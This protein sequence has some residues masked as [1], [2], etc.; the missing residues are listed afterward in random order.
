MNPCIRARLACFGT[1]SQ[2]RFV[3][4]TVL[5]VLSGMGLCL[6]ARAAGAVPLGRGASAPAELAVSFEQAAVLA[7]ELTAGGDA[8]FFSVAREPQGYFNRIVRRAGVEVVDALGDARF[9]LPEGAVPLKSVWVVADVETG[10]CTVAAPSGFPLRQVPFPGKAFEVGPPGLVNRLRHTQEDVDLVLVRPGVGAWRLQTHDGAPT[11]RDEE[12]GSGVLTALEDL[13]P[14]DATGLPPP[15]RY[16]A[17][18]V[19]VVID[20]RDLTFYATRL[21]GPPRPARGER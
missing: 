3:L 20:A 13:E 15:D 8:L 7:S 19:L 6:P 16:A 21:I 11:G 17:G 12:A 5:G 1:A 18:D 10:D 9:D 2:R 4:A 14:V